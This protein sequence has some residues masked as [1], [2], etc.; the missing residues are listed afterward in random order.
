MTRR[1]PAAAALPFLCVWLW[2]AGGALRQDVRTGER[3]LMAT[4]GAT[5]PAESAAFCRPTCPRHTRHA[6]CHAAQTSIAQPEVFGQRRR[7]A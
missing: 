4:G 2:V 1:V 5:R 6:R 7:P 3:R